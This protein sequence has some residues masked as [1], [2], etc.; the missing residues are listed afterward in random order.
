M[1]NYRSIIRKRTK[2]RFLKSNRV[3]LVQSGEDFFSRLE[4][5]IRGAV[6]E[7][8]LQ[9]YIFEPDETGRRI[10][11]ALKASA[12]LRKVK[13]FVLI[14]AYGSQ[15]FGQ[16]HLKE[17]REAGI[18][19]K[20]FGKFYSRGSFHIGRR[21]H[22]KVVVADGKIA[23]VGGINISNKYTDQEGSPAWL[24][25][26][27]QV[28]GDSAQRLLLIC[29]KR[30][31][32][33]RFKSFP[34]N[35]R[36]DITP[37][38]IP[39]IKGVAVKVSQNDYIYGKNEIARTYRNQIRN[40]K[41]SLT[42]VGGYFLPG[43]RI[44]KLLKEAVQRG[45]D[46]KL[47]VSHESDVKL[48]LLARRYLYSWLLRNKIRIYEYLPSN[49]HG[50]VLISDN[51]FTSIGSYDLNNLSTYSNIELNLDIADAT[52]SENFQY[53]LDKIITDHC[54]LITESVFRKRM[55]RYELFLSWISYQLVKTFFVLALW[56]A[57]KSE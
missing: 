49:V 1:A 9:I 43:G 33:S 51:N 16:F 23:L 17:M 37:N 6:N 14:D 30:W 10:M 55:N 13:I 35:L 47:I 54:S 8:H 20:Y 7:I 22:R 24:D 46:I 42:I 19:F 52:F 44:R 21:L 25:F 41:S 2:E 45:V 27:V 38:I 53:R 15:N 18:K 57:K 4:N 32:N 56:F 11:E 12:L 36:H 50:K 48:V 40:C 5:I 28:Q 26:S 3:E 31:M 34:R 29:R 39:I